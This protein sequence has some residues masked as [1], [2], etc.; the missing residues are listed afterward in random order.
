MDS[1]QQPTHANPREAS[2]SRPVAVSPM[3]PR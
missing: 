2:V 3:D 1:P